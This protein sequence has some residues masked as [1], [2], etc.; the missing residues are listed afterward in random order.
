MQPIK[1]R[2]LATITRHDAAAGTSSQFTTEVVGRVAWCLMALLQAGPKGCT[3]IT[4]PAPRWSHYTWCLRGQGIN[5]VTIDEPHD[6]AYSGSHARYV[7]MDEVSIGGG[8]LDQFLA[9][10]EGREFADVAFQRRAA[11]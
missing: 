1:P 3:P 10:P 5:V 4:R 9:A 8:N 2:F 7:L 11:A 6:G